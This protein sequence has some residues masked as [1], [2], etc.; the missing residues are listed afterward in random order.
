ME[1]QA[2]KMCTQRGAYDLSVERFKHGYHCQQSNDTW[3]WRIINSG[4]IVSQGVAKDLTAAQEMA[5]KNLP[6]NS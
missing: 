5:E 4:V 6:M 2:E 3:K 1:W